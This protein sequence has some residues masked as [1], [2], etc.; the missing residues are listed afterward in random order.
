VLTNIRPVDERECARVL[1]EATATHTPIT[2]LG[3]GSKQHV[4]R[5][6]NTA[7][8]IS[9][10]GLRGVTLYAARCWPSSRSSLP[11]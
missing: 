10:K 1:A 7:A 2:V 9:T 8:N 6:M 3:G 4:G 5:P 11:C